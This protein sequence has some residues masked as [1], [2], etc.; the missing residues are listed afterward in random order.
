MCG[1]SK[2]RHRRLVL[3]VAGKVTR[4]H[5]RK[6]IQQ[7]HYDGAR[8]RHSVDRR[9]LARSNARTLCRSTPVYYYRQRF[10]GHLGAYSAELC[11]PNTA[12]FANTHAQQ[13][14][15]RNGSNIRPMVV[16]C[17]K[18]DTHHRD[19]KSKCSARARLGSIAAQTNNC[20]L[21]IKRFRTIALGQKEII[22][23]V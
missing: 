4:Q 12:N 19:C 23:S 3:R 16:Q 11:L 14:L 8:T 10:S 21:R 7:C 22:C 13:R 20:L 18:K 2:P 6:C 15:Y 9:R 17:R 1:I 5:Q